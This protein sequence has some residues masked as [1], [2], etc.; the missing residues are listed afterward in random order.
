MDGG[1]SE[2]GA[3][4]E[5]SADC[6]GGT[7]TK[8]RTCTNPA[9]ANGGA[10]CAGSATETQ[11][12][13]TQGCPV[14][15]G[16]SDFGDWSECSVECEGGTQTR[17]RTCTN[18]APANGGTDCVGDATETQN[19]NTNPCPVDGG[20]SDFGAWSQCSAE[21]GGGTQTRTRT[22]TN[23]AP[24]NGGADCEGSA[25]ETQYCNEHECAVNGDWSDFGDWSECSADCGGGTQTRTRTC[26]N[27]TP[28]NR[29]ADCVGNATETQDCNK[30]EC[31]VDGGWSEFGDWS[32]CSADCGGGT[33]TRTRTCTNPAPA[34]EGA[35]C[36]GDATE[37]QDCNTHEC[38]VSGGWSDFGDWSECSADC[39]GGTQIRTRTCT[40]PA[41]A[42]GGADCVGDA[43]E[44]KDCNT[45]PC[46]V[47]GGW[48]EF[49]AWSECSADCEGGTQTRTRTCTNPAPVY[50][51]ADCVGDAT[52][53]QNCNLNPCPVDGGWS[54]FGA[55]SECSADCGG[56]TQKRTRTCTNP[57][58]ANGGADCVGDATETQDCNT[59]ECPVNGGW[60]D[61]GDWSECSADCG[62]GTQ[63]RTRTCTN[64]A[65]ANWGADCVGDASE[66]QNCNEHECP[67]DGG[68]SEFGAWSECSADCGGGT[69]KRTRTCTNPAPANG[70]AHCIGNS[71]VLE[72]CNK[73][74]TLIRFFNLQY[75]LSYK[76][77]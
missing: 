46:P 64:P 72:D 15:G 11:E 39:G 43:T 61:F 38:P 44:T 45:N 7:K 51:G 47:D 36:V 4:S 70:G 66:T 16:Y 37:T 8:N 25:T 30:H 55:W 27:P 75:F 21:C 56:G 57:A 20:W 77:F 23:P 50:G 33:Q 24:A 6:G 76:N 13:N 29:G 42:N 12:C 22:C 14:D 59:H 31:P 9:P 60:S 48:S 53:T 52:E 67:V 68:W 18:P 26:T 17:T 49:G 73:A 41:P 58:P 74:G 54:E 3:W 10:D 62:G 19:C 34:N 63:I 65:P 5:C 69:R 28:A 2:F 71:I 1:W 35:D 32:Q 40:N